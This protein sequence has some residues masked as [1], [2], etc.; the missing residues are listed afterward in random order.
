MN[1]PNRGPKKEKYNGMLPVCEIFFSIQGEG[2]WIGCP[3]IFIRFQYCNLG[4]D[5]CDTKFAWCEEE[6]NSSIL[7]KPEKIANDLLSIAPPTR[8]AGDVPHVVLTGGEPLLHQDRLPVLIDRLRAKGYTY[9]ELETNGTIVPNQVML[10]KIS[11]WNCSPK[12]SNSGIPEQLR[13]NPKVL[14]T[15]A[16][17]ENADFKFVVS[18]N[19]DLEEIQST[20]GSLVKTDQTMLMPEGSDRQTQL[21]SMDWVIEQCKDR[22]YRFTPRLHTIAWDNEKGR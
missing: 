22:G 14:Y 2:R 18:N 1:I 3:A 11:W 4:C 17:L 12:L 5:Y 19:N 6:K 8:W 15:I 9:F 21:T 13:F 16:K 20:F 10:E 7:F